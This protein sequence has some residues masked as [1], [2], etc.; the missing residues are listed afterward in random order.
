MLKHRDIVDRILKERSDLT[1]DAVKQMIKKKRDEVGGLLTEEGAAYIVASELGVDLKEADDLKTEITIRDLVPGINDVSISGR[2]LLVYPVQFFPRQDKTMGKVAR[3]VIADRTGMLDVVLWDNKTDLVCQGKIVQNQ[4]IQLLHGYVRDGLSGKPELNIGSRGSIIID[5]PNVK[6]EKFPDVREF[7]KKITEV[8]E[9]DI[10]VNIIGYVQRIFPPTTFSK[11]DGQVG[12]VIRLQ[13]ADETGKIEAVFWNEKVEEIREIRKGHCLQIMGGRIAKGFDERLEIHVEKRSQITILAEDTLPPAPPQ[14]NLLKIADLKAGMTD[15][16]LLARVLNIGPIREFKRRS[17]EIGYVTTLTIKDETGSIQLSLWDAHAGL[18]DKI[19]SG[20]I[21][22][23]EGAYT[24]ERFGTISLNLGKVGSLTLNPQ[25]AR[26]ANLPQ[27]EETMQIAQ[28]KRGMTN[29][30]IEGTIVS[31]PVV[32]EV[33]TMGG[34]TVLVASFTLRDQTGEVKASMWRHL[35]ALSKE[36]SVGN[37]IK[38]KNAYVKAGLA[39]E[40]E[41]SSGMHTTIEVLSKT[42]ADASSFQLVIE[43]AAPQR[44][45]ITSLVNGEN[46]EVHAAIA[47]V[48]P[49]PCIHL[50]CPKCLGKLK[51]LGENWRCD[52]CGVVAE[53]SARLIVEILLNDGTGVINALFFGKQAEEILNMPVEKAQEII[54]Q[55]GDICAPLQWISEKLLGKEII[56][57][58]KTAFNQAINK[59]QLI[60]KEAWLAPAQKN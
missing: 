32:R 57:I 41:L 58:G 38:I 10:Y 2:V 3:L 20:D 18:A 13:L 30:T 22:L 12:K 9:N 51:K 8:S 23:I 43:G 37:Q 15:V 31:P 49:K 25:I 11:P 55:T 1:L 56:V 48:L 47:E 60:V 7:F 44:K 53:P 45:K 17:G 46:V 4:I 50:V 33:V 40:L 35:A 28:L 6:P 52:S 24:K 59:M 26:A 5:P 27:A 21:V 39:E 14:I 54:N 42:S 19:K 36:L 16:S 34:E 29:V